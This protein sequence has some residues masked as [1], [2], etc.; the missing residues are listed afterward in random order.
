M[1]TSTAEDASREKTPTRAGTRSRT[2]ADK[3]FSRQ[4]WVTL[5]IFSLADF[6]SAVCVSLQAPFY[7]HEAEKKGATATQYGF[8]FGIFEL[9][10]FLVSPL[11][12]KYL[13]R[14]GPKFVFNAGIFTTAS[15]SILFGFLDKVYDT[16]LFIGLSFAIRIVEAMGNAGFLTASF[17]IIAKEFPDNVATTF[18]S[19]ET[20]FGIGL[21]VGPTVG[22]AL[23]Q[24]GGYTLPF[25]SL[26]GVLFFT[27]ILTFIVLPKH[28]DHSC[29]DGKG[30]GVRKALRVPGIAVA[31][32]SIVSASSSIGFIQALMEPH[33]RQFE[34]K[35]VVLGLMFVINGAVYALCAPI[36]GWL[37]DH[38]LQPK[39][40]T[41]IS[42][43][44]V[45]VGF[46]LLGPAPFLGLAPSLGL[47]SV[48]LVIHG[49]GFGGE[50]V[51][52]FVDAHREAVYNGFPDN[53]D[54]Y[55]MVSGLWTSMFALGAF[56][57]PSLAGI[58]YDHFGFE[59]ATLMIIVTHTLLFLVVALFL[60][61]RRRRT[62]RELQSANEKGE[63]EQ[64]K[65]PMLTG[66]FDSSYG[67]E[68]SGSNSEL[69][70]W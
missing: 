45:T 6:C 22:G 54:T 55:S 35:P 63:Q 18:A 39:V 2:M 64:E 40:A 8:V 42:A 46:A 21:I 65:M 11:Y 1:G 7:P 28:D 69:V 47:I 51:A 23:Y 19:L 34:L 3:G 9:T 50:V 38:H 49:V 25:V 17:A 15:C 27:A 29:K 10:V 61:V 43:V 44:L 48:A 52:A 26:G 67:S 56:I 5:F 12:G 20:F 16:E 58:L 37:C 13:N 31:A 30:G 41:A 57:G 24:V 66:S 4:Q 53:L 68:G 59:Y 33:L 62:F 36:W 14:I 60:C 70:V 32:F